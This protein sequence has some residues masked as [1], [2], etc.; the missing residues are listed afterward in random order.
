VLLPLPLNLYIPRTWLQ[1]AG[2]GP[3]EIACRLVIEDQERWLRAK[4]LGSGTIEFA[5]IM[6][7]TDP[8]KWRP[9]H[10]AAVSQAERAL[11]EQIGRM[12]GS[13]V[14]PGSGCFGGALQN[15][16]GQVP[17]ARMASRNTS[18]G[19]REAGVHPRA[20]GPELRRWSA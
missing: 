7:T 13:G 20:R 19:T 4:V 17:R 5:E 8:K 1:P 12:M 9:A 18:A 10:P 16:A 15:P 14:E 11:R 2:P 3:G 6:P